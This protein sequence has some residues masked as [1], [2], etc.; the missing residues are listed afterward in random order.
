[1]DK[2]EK[3]NGEAANEITDIAEVAEEQPEVKKERRFFSFFTFWKKASKE[4]VNEVNQYLSEGEYVRSEYFGLLEDKNVIMI[5]ME[6][7][8]W[9]AVDEYLTPNIYN[10]A[11]DNLTFSNHY[12]NNKTNV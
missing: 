9:F 7:F 8:Q 1:M 10:L 12:S 4:T 2:F 5:M 11:K 3:I 6:S